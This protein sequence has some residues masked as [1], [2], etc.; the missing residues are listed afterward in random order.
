[1]SQSMNTNTCQTQLGAGKSSI[2][3]IPKIVVQSPGPGFKSVL[4]IQ[5]GDYT[6]GI[7]TDTGDTFT[8]Q[9][10]SYLEYTN[11][12]NSMAKPVYPEDSLLL[13]GSPDL[14]GNS[15]TEK[16]PFSP[17]ATI[18]A[19]DDCILRFH[20][21]FHRD[22][23]LGKATKGQEL[24]LHTNWALLRKPKSKTDSIQIGTFKRGDKVRVDQLAE[25]SVASYGTRQSSRAVR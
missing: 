18:I 12:T 2:W 5:C 7:P 4:T 24:K 11:G 3:G 17:E 19:T 23:D 14:D 8:F 20:S 1:M 21:P 25:G 22:R 6:Q 15:R 9:P 10:A 13:V 16:F